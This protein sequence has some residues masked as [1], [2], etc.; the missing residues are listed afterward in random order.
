VN[1]QHLYKSSYVSRK[2]SE[3]LQ[4]F[5]LAMKKKYG[6]YSAGCIDSSSSQM[7]DKPIDSAAKPQQLD[8][9]GSRSDS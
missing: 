5:L 3:K 4:K 6:L 7:G 9:F 1:I 2:Y 8:L